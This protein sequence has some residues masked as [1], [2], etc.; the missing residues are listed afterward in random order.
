MALLSILSLYNYDE[1][2]LDGLSDALPKTDG[3]PVMEYPE[4]YMTPEPM[5]RNVMIS[6]I[7]M[8][9]EPFEVLYPDPEI[10]KTFIDIWAKANKNAWQALYNTQW[11]K[12]NPIWNKD[13]KITRTEKETR[14]LSKRNEYENNGSNDGQTT[15][16]DTTTD[17]GNTTTKV[18]GFNTDNLVTRDSVDAN[19]TITLDGSSAGKTTTHDDGTSE[20][21]DTGT[22]TREYTENEQGNIGVTM[23][24]D[25][26]AKQRE[27]ALFNVYDIIAEDFKKTFFVMVY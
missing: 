23:T 11:L 4:S 14:D 20:T 9:C 18:T 3:V 16:K 19:D 15:T 24:Q 8:A 1:T 2:I 5:D 13:G 21:T 17:V 26:I 10:L 27:V 7:M 6:K 12:Y 22:V 25:M